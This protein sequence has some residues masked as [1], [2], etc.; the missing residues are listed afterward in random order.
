MAILGFSFIKFEAKRSVKKQGGEIKI[1]HNLGINIVEKTQVN[2]GIKTE[3]V[4]R[5][6][7]N[8]DVN[9]SEDLGKILIVGDVL[10]S[11]TKE[12]I[13]ESLLIWEKDKQLNKMVNEIVL[14][15]VYNKATIKALELADSLNLPSPIPIPNIEFKDK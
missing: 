1:N 3:D 12:I 4:L 6:E 5:I 8:F 7:F 14:K 9:Y 2:V 15:F 11:D 10:Y 13:K